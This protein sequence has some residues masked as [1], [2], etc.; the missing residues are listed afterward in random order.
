MLP[1]TQRRRGGMLSHGDGPTGQPGRVDRRKRLAR[2][3]GIHASSRRRV[4]RALMSA[5]SHAPFMSEP[6]AEREPLAERAE[7][8]ETACNNLAS[9]IPQRYQA[10][11]DAPGRPSIGRKPAATGANRRILPAQTCALA[12]DATA[13]RTAG[14]I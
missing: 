3:A 6:G 12:R 5:P 2:I 10:P 4:Y 8:A 13:R 14:R 11:P 9:L 1:L 7:R